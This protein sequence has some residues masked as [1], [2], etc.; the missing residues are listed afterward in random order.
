[1]ILKVRVDDRLLHGQ[2]AYSWKAKLGYNAIVIVSDVA[3]KDDL[4]K[5]TIKMCCP[6]GVKLATRTVEDA[7]ALLKNEKLKSMKVFVICQDP[8]TAYEVVTHL[9]EKPVVNLGGLQM[10][11]GSE[12]FA[13][14]VYMTKEDYLYCDKL[15]DLGFS[16]EVQEVPETS[17]SNYKNLRK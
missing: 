2:V 15:I 7:I 16:I 9:D 8:K 17:M 10:R 12:Y 13:K 6:D 14:A 4:R 5:A 3:A 11:D 1:M